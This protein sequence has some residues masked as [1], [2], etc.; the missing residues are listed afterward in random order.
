ML[1]GVSVALGSPATSTVHS[2]DARTAGAW[3]CRPLRFDLASCESAS[4]FDPRLS[5]TIQRAAAPISVRTPTPNDTLKT[6]GSLL[7]TTGLSLALMTASAAGVHAEDV[8]VQSA[9]GTNGADGVN[10]GYDGATGGNG[11]SAV[12]NASSGSTNS[13]TAFGGDGGVSASA[14]ATGGNTGQSID[15]GGAGGDAS[16]T[17]TAIANGSGNASASANATG[18]AG[19]KFQFGG[20][21][22]GWPMRRRRV[23]DCHGGRDTG[24]WCWLRALHRQPVS[25]AETVN[26][27]MA[28]A[29]ST[30]LKGSEFYFQIRIHEGNESISVIV[31]KVKKS[32]NE[33]R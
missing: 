18:G 11:E 1:Q 29:L 10:P 24:C 23:G 6:T 2:A 21:A 5:Q 17:S 7:Q 14:S 15:V 28:Q 8:T 4:E 33:S 20:N 16:A 19:G 3:H 30:A 22:T 12:A 31:W 32:L 26:G 25:N 9:G 27:A 13:A